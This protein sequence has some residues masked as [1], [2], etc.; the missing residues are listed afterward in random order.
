[1]QSFNLRDN[2]HLNRRQFIQQFARVGFA[3]AVPEQESM[4]PQLGKII[5]N[6][7]Q[8]LISTNGALFQLPFLGLPELQLEVSVASIE[9]NQPQQRRELLLVLRSDA[10]RRHERGVRRACP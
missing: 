2:L 1:M 9:R 7:R 6:P 5:G 8:S 3:L 10:R 4:A